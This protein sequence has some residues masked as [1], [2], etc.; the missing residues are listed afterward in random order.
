MTFNETM[1]SRLIQDFDAQLQKELG[2]DLYSFLALVKTEKGE[3]FH[4]IIETIYDRDGPVAVR[5]FFDGILKLLSE[6]VYKILNQ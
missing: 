2:A 1:R 4:S 5:E 3:E 6:F